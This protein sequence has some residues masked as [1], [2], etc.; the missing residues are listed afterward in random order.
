MIAVVIAWL[1]DL[2][3]ALF[4]TRMIGDQQ[5]VW[6]Q[7]TIQ[8]YGLAIAGA[9]KIKSTPLPIAYARALEPR[10]REPRATRG[11]RA[12]IRDV[13][14]LC[15]V[16][17]ASLLPPAC[18]PVCAREC[19][20]RGARCARPA[21]T[22]TRLRPSA[23]LPPARAG[24]P[25]ARSTT[26]ASV[27][28]L[29]L[30]VCPAVRC[31]SYA[32]MLTWLLYIFV[33]SIPFVFAGVFKD[34]LA[35]LEGERRGGRFDEY[36]RPIAPTVPLM[37]FSAVASFFL[38]FALLGINATAEE[39]EDPFGN[40]DNDLPMRDFLQATTDTLEF[41]LQSS[42]LLS[43]PTQADEANSEHD[44]P[45]GSP[46]RR[47]SQRPAADRN[48]PDKAIS[49]APKKSIFKTVQLAN[50]LRRR[51]PSVARL[52]LPGAPAA[53]T[54]RG[55]RNETPRGSKRDTPRGS[56]QPSREREGGV[57]TPRERT[58][59]RWHPFD[60]GGSSSVNAGTA[61][62]RAVFSAV[63]KEAKSVRIAPDSTARAGSPSEAARGATRTGSRETDAGTAAGGAH[64]HAQDV[65]DADGGQVVRII[66]LGDSRATSNF[67]ATSNDDSPDV[68]R[69]IPPQV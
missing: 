69:L 9:L 10:A 51:M 35:D 66:H 28:P 47:K 64:D 12:M 14:Y 24:R 19:G 62:T 11:A 65:A 20:P 40:D 58:G 45:A 22:L 54:P 38:A 18:V 53:E 13:L 29:S 37:I 5:L 8:N 6:L 42:D 56:R 3:A 46:T 17:S 55:S 4:H 36:G 2:N 34:S 67:G 16:L 44:T 32:Q 68:R 52:N 7:E 27:R 23:P 50:Q 41:V 60:R 48:I 57:T 63:P 43:D 25:R 31:C 1:S 26:R 61:V 33:L 30:C 39:L 21:V 49:H 59:K 15:S